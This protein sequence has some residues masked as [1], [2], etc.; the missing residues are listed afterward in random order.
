MAKNVKKLPFPHWLENTACTVTVQSEDITP[1]GEQAAVTVSGVKCI[2]DEKA[3]R[4]TDKDGKDIRSEARVIIRGDIA[5]GLNSVTSGTVKINGGV[6]TIVRAS[7]P[8]NPDGTV[9][10]TELE[11]I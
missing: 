1:D 7:R 10:H 6:M 5:P 8:R 9:H 2:Y 4:V 11:L 3:R